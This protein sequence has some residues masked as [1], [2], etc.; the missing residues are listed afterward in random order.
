MVK[1]SAVNV[2]N[3]EFL[4]L[5][6]VTW[7]LKEYARTAFNKTKSDKSTKRSVI[8]NKCVAFLTVTCVK[9]TS[10][11]MLWRSPLRVGVFLFVC[12]F[13]AVFKNAPNM[14]PRKGSTFMFRR[15]E[16]NRKYGQLVCWHS[17]SQRLYYAGK[18][19]TRSF[20]STVWPTVRTNTSRKRSFSKTLFKPGEFENASRPRRFRVD[21]AEPIKSLWS[22]D[23]F[24]VRVF[25]KLK[26]KMA[27]G[28]C[29][30]IEIPVT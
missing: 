4:C 22:C 28:C 15:R 7:T 23:D 2:Q 21:V 29:V 16:G 3:R 24:P 19:W 14:S 25:L 12:L 10:V 11:T 6:L 30:F 13:N 20:I 17:L 27:A 5:S 8:A 18:I 1:C 26:S 9:L